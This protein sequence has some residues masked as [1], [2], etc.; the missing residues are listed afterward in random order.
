MPG[1][2]Y[3]L[4]QIC[5]RPGLEKPGPVPLA[6]AGTPHVPKGRVLVGPASPPFPLG[7]VHPLLLFPLNFTFL[8]LLG[9]SF[10]GAVI[11]APPSSHAPHAGAAAFHSGHADGHARLQTRCFP[12]YSPCT[13]LHLLASSPSMAPESPQQHRAWISGLQVGPRFTRD[14]GG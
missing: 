1:R 3:P 4:T 14:G 13:C 11:F 5:P 8:Q 7:K 6:Q 10:L 12:I 2:N 9:F